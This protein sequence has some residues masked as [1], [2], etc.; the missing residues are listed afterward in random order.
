MASMNRVLKGLGAAAVL[1]AAAW[2]GIDLSQSEGNSTASTTSTSNSAPVQAAQTPNRQQQKTHLPSCPTDTLP[3]QATEVIDD[4]LAGGPF[5][6][7]EYD[8]T[9]FGNYERVL[10]KQHNNFYREYTVDTPGLRH[11]GERRIVV[12]GGTKQDPDT[13]YYT[14][15]HYESFCMIPDA[16][17]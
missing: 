9:H 1:V 2:L 13:W 10:P 7:P 15:D 3:Q 17:D 16:E 11:R 12:G 6:H 14:D 8:G 5:E 4:I